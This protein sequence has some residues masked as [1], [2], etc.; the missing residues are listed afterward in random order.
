MDCGLCGRAVC[1]CYMEVNRA[2]EIESAKPGY[3]CRSGREIESGYPE[4]GRQEICQRTAW[5]VRK[6]TA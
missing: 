6:R 4:E 2:D 1:D 5:E 3:A